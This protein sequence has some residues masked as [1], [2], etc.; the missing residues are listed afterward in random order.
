MDTFY[1]PF[2]AIVHGN[3]DQPPVTSLQIILMG[4]F[5][6]GIEVVLIVGGRELGL[7]GG[8][9]GLEARLGVR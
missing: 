4:F 7:K 8:E 1:S 6:R 9:G 5:A 2:S 3:P